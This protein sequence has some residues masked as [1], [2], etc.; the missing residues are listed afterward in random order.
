MRAGRIKYLQQSKK[1][2]TETPYFDIEQFSGIKFFISFLE[3]RSF[4]GC[5]I[6]SIPLNP[7][8]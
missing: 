2:K 7:I 3:E 5:T 6:S 4:R 8:I 1:I